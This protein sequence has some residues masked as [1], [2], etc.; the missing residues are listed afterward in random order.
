MDLAAPPLEFGV[1]HVSKHPDNPLWNQATDAPWVIQT[2]EDW[3]E[4]VTD[5]YLTAEHVLARLEAM[6]RVAYDQP[7]DGAAAYD[8][9]GFVRA[10]VAAA[11][12][13]EGFRVQV[14]PNDHR[15]P[16]AHFVDPGEPRQEVRLS[17]E[18]GDPL[19]GESV[20]VGQKKKLRKAKALIGEHHDL[21]MDWWREYQAS[22]Q[23]SP[24]SGLQ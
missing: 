21:L 6:V 13:G 1:R 8:E 11:I 22:Q 3:D 24:T 15:P 17:L 4:A 2:K 16:H 18:T 14:H 23:G 19:D 20:P 5:G 10:L 12:H 9:D 7:T